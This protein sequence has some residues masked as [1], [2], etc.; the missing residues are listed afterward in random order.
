MTMYIFYY[1]VNTPY[2]KE[3][4]ELAASLDQFGLRYKSY[5]V[6][7]K[8]NWL[9][10]VCLKSGIILQAWNDFKEPLVYLDADARVVQKP[11]LFDSLTCDLGVHIRKQEGFSFFCST[12]YWGRTETSHK[13]LLD[14][15]T[16][17]HRQEKV[18]P[19][20]LP[21]PYYKV[22]TLDWAI[23]DQGPLVNAYLSFKDQGINVD[24]FNLPKAYAVKSKSL[25]KER[26]IVQTQKS[27]EY[28]K[29]IR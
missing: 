4:A 2:E 8:G 21:P 24:L 15:D 27:I 16:R 13:L 10:N 17:C 9:D 29:L 7:S 5:P 12:M 11:K 22:H 18:I 25:H 19:R 20:E 26:I 14:W 3:A 23:A 28:R 1:T 6:R